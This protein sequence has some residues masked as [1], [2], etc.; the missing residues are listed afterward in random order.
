VSGDAAR[1]ASTSGLCQLQQIVGGVGHRPFAPDLIEPSRQELTEASGLLDLPEYRLDRLTPE[2]IPA[3]A[4]P[5]ASRQLWPFL[6]DRF[7]DQAYQGERVGS[8]VE[9]VRPD[10]GQKGFAVQPRRWV[11]ERTFGRIARCRRL[12]RDYEA[13]P[14][15]A[16][17]FFILAAAMILVRRRAHPS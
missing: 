11:I 1:A 3:V 7:A 17:A 10:K 15:P 4:L 9:I 8:A 2:A 12:A 14:S 16:L 5:R 6:A 13:P